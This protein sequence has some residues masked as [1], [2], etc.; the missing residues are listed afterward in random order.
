MIPVAVINKID[1]RVI[2]KI[3]L[4]LASKSCGDNLSLA[5]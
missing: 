2:P 3:N 1:P 4:S 5:I